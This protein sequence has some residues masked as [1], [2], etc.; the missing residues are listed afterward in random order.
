MSTRWLVT[1]LEAAAVILGLCLTW[2]AG[3]FH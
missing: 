2:R 3:G 1:L